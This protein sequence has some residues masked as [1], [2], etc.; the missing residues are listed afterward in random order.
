MNKLEKKF[1]QNDYTPK[2]FGLKYNPPQ[3]VVEYLTP[4]TGKLYHHKIRLGKFKPE[5]N[6][7][8]VVKEVYE[9]HYMYLDNKKVNPAQIVRLIEKLNEKRKASNANSI[10]S[11][12]P[13]EQKENNKIESRNINL[14]KENVITS[15]DKEKDNEQKQ[16]ISPNKVDINELD[17]EEEDYYKFF[18]Y[19]NEDLNKLDTSELRKRKDQMEKLYEKNAVLPGDE[20]FVFDVRVRNIFLE[21]FTKLQ[22]LFFT[23]ILKFLERF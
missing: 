21:N 1:N 8:E 7:Q 9:K 3:I 11:R 14:S 18:D 4:S 22:K 19:E 13:K 12:E 17:D 15:N 23:K 16:N 5:T 20:K 2:R 6:L 10:D